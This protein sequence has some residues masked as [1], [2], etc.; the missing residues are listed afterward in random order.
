LRDEGGLISPPCP[1][2]KSWI[3][4]D[5]KPDGQDGDYK[6]LQKVYIE[7]VRSGGINVGDGSR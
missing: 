1:F 3:S 6:N 4:A 7:K 5:L 2:H